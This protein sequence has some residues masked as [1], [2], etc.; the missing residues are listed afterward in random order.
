M[1]KIIGFLLFLCV[2][3][4]Q[5]AFAETSEFREEGRFGFLGAITDDLW[6]GGFVYEHEKFEVQALYH[7]NWDDG[8]V[9]ESHLLTKVG[10]R[11]NLE[12]YNYLAIGAQYNAHPFAHAGDI[13]LSST[14]ET[15]PYV[16]FQRYFPG[17]N[18]MLQIWV[19][20]VLFEHAVTAE[21]QSDGSMMAVS[22]NSRRIMQTG[23]FG[24]TY[25]F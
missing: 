11:I 2:I 13:S 1:I 20:P 17:T 19:N 23:G 9:V 21:T 10:Y 6:K 8:D 14:Y 25:L 12:N 16:S 22:S 3:Q 5:S 24:V 7:V 15:G 18:I 4:F